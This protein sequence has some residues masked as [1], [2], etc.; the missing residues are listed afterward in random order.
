MAVASKLSVD[1]FKK[2]LAQC[3]KEVDEE[4]ISRS[5]FVTADNHHEMARLG[6]FR[7]A[8]IEMVSKFNMC[9]DNPHDFADRLFGKKEEDR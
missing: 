7:A 5:E 3:L 1:L 9:A 2:Y 4:I 6:H 8:T